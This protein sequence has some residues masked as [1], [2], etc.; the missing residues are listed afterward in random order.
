[1]ATANS[2]RNADAR[3]DDLYT[4]PAWATR[5]LLDRE[6]FTDSILD[7]GC[8]LNDI[9]KVFNERGLNPHGIDLS[10]HGYGEVGVNFLDYKKRFDNV[11]SNPPFTLLTEFINKACELATDKVAIFARINALET[12]GRFADIYE[13]NAPQRVYL[14]TNRVNCPKGGVAESES[15]AVLYCWIIWDK[16]VQTDGTQLLWINDEAPKKPRKPRKPRKAKPEKVVV[17]CNIEP[18][19]D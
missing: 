17:D 10:D 9:T 7:A 4:T 6:E 16:S 12:K 8:G 11:V 15:S 13:H 1:M 5:A 14:F 19:F 18:E 2:R 3:E